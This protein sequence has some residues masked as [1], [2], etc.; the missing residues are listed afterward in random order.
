MNASYE[1]RKIQ[2]FERYIEELREFRRE[3]YREKRR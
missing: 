3:W 1:E 2:N